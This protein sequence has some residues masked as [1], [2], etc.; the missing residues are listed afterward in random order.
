MTNKGSGQ[1]TPRIQVAS[2]LVSQAAVA[3]TAQNELTAESSQ[4]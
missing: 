3:L 2:E 4:A 1:W